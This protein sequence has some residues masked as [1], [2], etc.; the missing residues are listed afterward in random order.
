MVEKK[1]P[2]GIIP[3]MITPM[4]ELGEV[5]ETS[6]R[7]LIEY[8]RPFSSALLPLLT[9]GEGWK[10]NRKQWL[11]MLEYTLKHSQGLPVLAGVE[12]PTTG[13]VIEYGL[14]AKRLGANA[15]VVTTPFH[16]HI[17]QSQIYNHFCGIAA[18]VDCAMII[19]HEQNFSGNHIELE[20]FKEICRLQHVAGIKEASGDVSFTNKLI[21]STKV[22]VFQGWEHL[23]FATQKPAG[24]IFPLANLE[25]QLCWEMYTHPSVSIQ[26]Q[27]NELCN[28]YDILQ[29]APHRNIKKQLKEKKII[30]SEV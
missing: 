19:Y 12:F 6:V 16:Q 25:P 23:A 21:Q 14:M 10:L 5:C 1:L 4:N 2:R 24:F 20:T 28:R 11:G 30:L 18:N 17:E 29:A 26:Q 27:L 8:I 3:P 13:Q 15:I 22:P 9:T 7:N